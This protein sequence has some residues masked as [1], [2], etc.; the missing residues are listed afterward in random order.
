MAVEKAAQVAALE[1][2]GQRVALGGLDLA[3][4][5]AQLGRNAVEAERRDRTR[6][7]RAWGRTRSPARARRRSRR[8][9][10]T[11]A[12]A[13]SARRCA[14]L[15]VAC[16]S[17]APRVHRGRHHDLRARPAREAQREPT[18]VLARELVHARQLAQ[19]LEQLAGRH[20]RHDHQHQVAHDLGA[21]ANVAGHDGLEHARASARAPPAALPPRPPRGASSRKAL[22]CRR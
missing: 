6:P 5:L 22:A 3:L 7:R 16:T 20:I 14:S 21:A 2:A 9:R 18:V 8:D 10:A 1:Q 11:A 15:P 4:A 17:T 12:C 13:A 19:P